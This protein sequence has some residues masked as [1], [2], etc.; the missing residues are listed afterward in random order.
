MLSS[1]FARASK[2]LTMRSIREHLW[3]RPP[4]ALALAWL[5]LV[6]P[7]IGPW[8]SSTMVGHMLVQIPL[9][10]VCG[11]ALGRYLL[12]RSP[13]LA[14]YTVAYRWPLMLCAVITLT[15]WMLPRLLDLA[16]ESTTVNAA[17]LL[18][19][20]F[21]AGLPLGVAWRSLGPV[22]R[23]LLHVEA[24]ATVWRVGWLYLDSPSR[25]CTQYVLDDQARAGTWML[26]LGCG[27]A[28]WLAV[29]ALTGWQT[30]T[31]RK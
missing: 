5:L 17:K 28:V 20:P 29:G 8:L 23:G 30:P 11:H 6:M 15:V 12:Q 16:L 7:P 2:G 3:G 1:G 10:V 4:L 31:Q 22:A 21:M 27:Y 13:T 26:A 18:S 25:L 9:L 14:R 19:L 24:L